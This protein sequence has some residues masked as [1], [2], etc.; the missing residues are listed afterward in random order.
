MPCSCEMVRKAGG[1][2]AHKLPLDCLASAQGRDVP[3]P[4]Q[5]ELSVGAIG[6]SPYPAHTPQSCVPGSE[7]GRAEL[8]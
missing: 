8:L 1:R 2:W 7:S 6:A 4:L 5:G 3:G